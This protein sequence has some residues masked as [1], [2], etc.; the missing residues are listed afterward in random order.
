[1]E[2]WDK[3]LCCYAC[4]ALEDKDLDLRLPDSKNS[5]SFL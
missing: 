2:H 3:S 5:L 1:M 4:A